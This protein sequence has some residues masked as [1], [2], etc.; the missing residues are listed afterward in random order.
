LIEGVVLILP[1]HQEDGMDGKHAVLTGRHIAAGRALIGM[2]QADLAARAAISI[3]TLKR[4]EAA[5]GQ[6]PGIAN[7]VSAVIRALEDAGLEFR[8]DGFLGVRTAV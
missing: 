3:P 5:Q 8:E 4:M 6:I 7:N 1:T 2:L